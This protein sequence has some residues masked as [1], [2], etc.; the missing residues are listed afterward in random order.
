MGKQPFKHDMKSLIFF[1]FELPFGSQ[2]QLFQV[3][4]IKDYFWLFFTLIWKIACF[5]LSDQLNQF[6][7]LSVQ[8]SVFQSLSGCQVGGIPSQRPMNASIS[9]RF[10]WIYCWSSTFC[11]IDHYWHKVLIPERLITSNGL[12]MKYFL[13]VIHKTRSDLLWH[14][15]VC[16][17]K[18][19]N[20]RAFMSQAFVVKSFILQWGRDLSLQS[21][22]YLYCWAEIH[23]LVLK[24]ASTLQYSRNYL[25]PPKRYTPCSW[26]TEGLVSQ[27]VYSYIKFSFFFSGEIGNMN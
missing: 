20:L 23:I 6:N 13:F 15:L 10:D 24:I 22:V 21:L 18:A 12:R 14:A 11:P 26:Y 19:L 7:N 27:L 25:P 5:Q 4:K 8:W 17:N 3:F 1:S 9:L 2:S 16:A